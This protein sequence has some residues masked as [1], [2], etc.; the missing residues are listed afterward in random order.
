V[1]KE[2]DGLPGLAVDRLDNVLVLH[3]FAPDFDEHA[4]ADALKE[5]WPSTRSI[6]VKRHPREAARAAPKSLAVLAPP[7]PM[8]GPP[9]PEVEVCENGLRFLARPG[10]GLSYGLFP[11]M[12]EVRT[13]V[14]EQ[15]GGRSVLN[16]FA[17][18]CGFGVAAMRGGAQRVLNVDLSRAALDWGKANYELN[19]FATDPQDF[20][21]GDASNWLKRFSRRGQTFDL[22]ILD[23]PSFSRGPSG[24]LAVEKEYAGLVTLAAGAV[25]PDGTLLAATNHSRLK[26]AR[27]QALLRAGL[28]DAGRKARL[29]R[30]WHEP[31]QD[32]PRPAGAPPALKVGALSLQAHPPSRTA[33]ALPRR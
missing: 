26:P 25:A 10:R 20:V 30:A 31:A 28:R 7:E 21:Y 29:L 23:P 19:G 6:Y 27:F 17:Y 3:V 18:T 2:G 4:L 15:A 33:A 9:V 16:L 32:Y 14:E 5:V 1:N 22:V 8:V 11:D 13:W 12:R 24:A